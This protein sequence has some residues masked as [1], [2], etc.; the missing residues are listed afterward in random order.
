V[1]ITKAFVGSIKEHPV[2]LL[3]P[4]LKGVFN[5]GQSIDYL[6]HRLTNQAGKILIEPHPDKLAEFDRRLQ[7]GLS[8]LKKAENA[9]Q[10]GKAER[11]YRFYVSPWTAAFS[12]CTHID[13]VRATALKR[14]EATKSNKQ[15]K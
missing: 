4:K 7:R 5:R 10:K 13:A 2:G 9:F 3:E 14:L 11:A 6:G 12:L 8:R 1:S 15:L